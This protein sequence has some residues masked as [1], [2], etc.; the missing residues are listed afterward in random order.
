MEA[1]KGEMKLS[2]SSSRQERLF[3]TL[4]AEMKGLGYS[5]ELLREGYEFH[6]YSADRQRVAPAAAF[7]RTP[8]SY[9]TA[10]FAILISNGKSGPALLKDFRAL[11]A[12]LA[13]EIEDDRV[14]YWRFAWTPSPQDRLQKVMPEE[15]KRLFR[16]KS[17][18]WTP[19]SILRAKSVGRS[20]PRQLDLFF[21]LGL[22]PALEKD[23][24]GKLEPLLQGA[25]AAATEDSMQRIRREPDAR[26]LFR[27]AFW[28]LAGKVFRD[29]G[30]P[31]FRSLELDTDPESVLKRV[32]RHYDED[33]PLSL[34][35][36]TRELLF[37]RLWTKLD[38]RNLSAEVLT[39]IW[40]NAFVPADMRRDL[41]IHGTPR[42]IAKYVVERLPI[43]SIPERHR[44]V[45]EPCC[46]SAT[47]LLAAQ[48][49]LRELLPPSM[50]SEERHDYL[51]RML[52]GFEQ[53]DVGI[54]ISRLN[55]TLAD[56]PNP[57]GW[58]LRETDIFSS[59]SF[60]AELKQA[61]IVLC[62]PPF[63]DFSREAREEYQLSSVH[64]PVELLNRVLDHLHPE[65]ILGF[66]LPRQALDGRGYGP[67]RK[68]AVER[69]E[70]IEVVELPDKVF[71]TADQETALFIASRP[72]PDGRS[73]EVTH[74]K[75]KEADLDRFLVEH[76]PSVENHET[77]SLEA[78]KSTI[79][80][81]ELGRVWSC[82]DNVP[83]LG[84]IAKI[85][86]GIEWN[87]PLT[88][89]G[90]ETG[91]RDVLVS[92][93]P[94]PGFREGIPP[95]AK[96]LHAFQRPATKFLDY[97]A[98]RQR[99]NA[100]KLDWDSPKVI[101]NASTKSRG[102][103]R[104][105]AFADFDRLVCYQT[106]TAVW[107][108]ESSLPQAAVLLAAVLNGPVAN[109]FVAV[110]EGKLHIKKSTLSSIPVPILPLGQRRLIRELIEDYTGAERAGD[111]SE[112][113]RLL[114]R[115]DAEVLRGYNL[116]PEPQR[117]L[118]DFFRGRESRRAVPFD[119]EGYPNDFP[120]PAKVEETPLTLW[121][122]AERDART[123]AAIELIVYLQRHLGEK[124]TAYI[125]G[126]RGSGTVRQW[127]SKAAQPGAK[128]QLRLRYAYH[129]TRLLVESYG[130]ETAISWLFGTNS[131]LND[132][133]PA[134]VLRRAAKDEDFRHVIPAARSFVGRAAG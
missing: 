41:G 5:D 84:D 89:D 94:R 80:V 30:V 27:L 105:A 45:L 11:G 98:E 18:I 133:A 40:A 78:A 12:P 58:Q 93:V 107:P 63:E 38:L 31:A 123:T 50:K 6:D 124:L 91:N 2:F 43:E 100:F 23:L 29:C 76:Q 73:I 113:Q 121:E 8:V 82:L 36:A 13:F 104:I 7:G 34:D 86:R 49:R 125:I 120:P 101:L 37:E 127:I 17:R 114:L 126:P 109:A 55:L 108:N 22:I 77:K 1:G 128:A 134:D 75:V 110:R 118:L 24:R 52:V 44:R 106:F 81:P 21:D 119:F 96:P 54:E 19:E 53:G 67:I 117:E 42:T 60:L 66:V 129:A 90:K 71:K 116:P 131:L 14:V 103:W 112:A 92:S 35:Q 33:L 85:S 65:G 26:Q 122:S 115:I 68:K 64:K 97:S 9:D 102:P 95:R 99:G 111:R 59:K 62:N 16:E 28:L 132:E 57:D 70:E 51:K 130:N 79:A 25:L 88:K 3:R 47:F 74:R 72:R 69:F 20:Q 87:I 61:R 15:I 48:Q 46:G 10:C 39:D 32:A 83:R 56:F 4:I